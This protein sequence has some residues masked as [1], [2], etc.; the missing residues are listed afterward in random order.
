MGGLLFIIYASEDLCF[1]CIHMSRL[2]EHAYFFCV[3][4]QQAEISLGHMAR[5]K[6]V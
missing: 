4:F 5:L 1:Y 6:R 3:F 2:A